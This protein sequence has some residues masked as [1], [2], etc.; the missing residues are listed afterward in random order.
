ML[1][2]DPGGPSRR[3]LCFHAAA[4]I[5]ARLAADCQSI[6]SSKMGGEASGG[7]PHEGRV[8]MGIVPDNTS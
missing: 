7:L 5:R 1:L 2:P 4:K 6:D 8:G 3:R